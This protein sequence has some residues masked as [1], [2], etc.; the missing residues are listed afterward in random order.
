MHTATM[1]MLIFA[2]GAVGAT[3][4]FLLVHLLEKR[5]GVAAWV[6]ILLVNILGCLL[7]G[8]LAAVIP[9]DDLEGQALLLI[10]LMG[11]FTTFS[12]A[13]LDAW[14]LRMRCDLLPFLLTY[15]GTAIV[16]IPAAALG[17]QLGGGGG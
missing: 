16:G 8:V 17:L 9:N 12:T 4:R 5:A 3:G 13:M 2:G 14:V 1:L 11:G 6:G 7:I 15:I 10:G